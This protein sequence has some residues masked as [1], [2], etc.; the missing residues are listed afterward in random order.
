MG[1]IDPRYKSMTYYNCGEPR[2]FI[3]ICNKPKVCFIYAILGH[4]MSDC[5]TWKKNQLVASY[6]GSATDG[7]GF[8]HVDLLECETTRW[9]NIK[10][11]GVVIVKKG[12]ISMFELEK[13]LSEF[14]CKEWPWQVRELITNRFLVR[15]QPHRKVA[16]I[17]ALPSFNLGKEGVQV[18]VV[19]W[20]GDLDHFSVLTE[21]LIQLEGIPPKW[22]D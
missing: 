17:K 7:L 22:C 18:E 10:N 8:Y 15:F 12:V 4:Y 14:F 20:I 2:H 6:I 13:E 21:T 19:E 16:N 3:R 11:C 9:L 1:A 5:P